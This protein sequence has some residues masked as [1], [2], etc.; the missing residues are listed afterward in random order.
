MNPRDF[1]VFNDHVK[2][3]RFSERTLWTYLVEDLGLPYHDWTTLRANSWYEAKLN[4]LARNKDQPKVGIQNATWAHPN[5]CNAKKTIVILQDNIIRMWNDPVPQ[6]ATLD[7]A[8]VVVCNGPLIANDYAS[9]CGTKTRIIPIGID[10]EFWKL[11]PRRVDD[12]MKTVV[13][14]GDAA[15]HKGYQHV[16]ALARRRDDLHW[17][18]VLKNPPE[19][20]P[21]CGEIHV[22][23]P[24]ERV[25]TMLARADAFILGSP[26]ETQCLAALEALACNVPVVMPPTG[27]FH[28]WKPPSY[29]QVDEQSV[30]F[31]EI[32]LGDALADRGNVSPRADLLAAGRFTVP[33]MLKSWRALLEEVVAGA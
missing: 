3:G 31:Y 1:L 21:P 24:A 32:A 11:A 30:D 4:I 23:L 13:F 26:V 28:D 20:L 29:Y 27:A 25:R 12:E 19:K 22:A 8:D 16:E 7:A 10:V 6:R 33:D 18:W 15:P 5:T 9:I 2:R 17:I 14:V